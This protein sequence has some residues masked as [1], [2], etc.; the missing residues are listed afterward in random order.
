MDEA[1]LS[2]VQKQRADELLQDVVRG[3][4][5]RESLSNER[6]LDMTRIS[7]VLRIADSDVDRAMFE[8]CRLSQNA[9]SG[10]RIGRQI[11]ALVLDVGQTEGPRL[12]GA[13][14]LASPL[15]ALA[16]RDQFLNWSGGGARSRKN[17]GLRR[18]MD[19]HLCTALPP[20]NSLFGG[21][22]L[23]ALALSREIRNEFQRKYEDP[24]LG[25]STS[26]VSGTHCALF[27]RIM[28]RQGGLSRRIG[29]TS[30]YTLA[31]MRPD[32]LKLARRV[33]DG[34]NAVTPHSILA[35][36]LKPLL[37]VR[38]ALKVLGVPFDQLLRL[39]REKGVYFAEAFP[40]AADL[41]R[42][43][44]R[45]RD[46]DSPFCAKDAIAFWR[47][48]YLSRRLPADRLSKQDVA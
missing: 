36:D 2:E 46:V 29:A 39:G 15:Y 1:R 4:A 41:L 33:A 6:D 18:M 26:C 48:N 30:G 27:N 8:Y 35:F 37:V 19:L 20:Y 9:P 24:L 42:T 22:L 44:A 28:L 17:A 13:F 14:G 23:A 10:K 47:D 3:Q 32:T 16:C 25:I 21:K 40:G 7:P 5:I 31:W 12:M 43:D 34:D 11:R 38:R 45:P